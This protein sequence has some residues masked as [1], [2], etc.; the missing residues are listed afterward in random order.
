MQL[1]TLALNNNNCIYYL[2]RSN[3]NNHSSSKKLRL[4]TKFIYF[5]ISSFFLL[6]FSSCRASYRCTGHADL[7]SFRFESNRLECVILA[8]IT[9]TKNRLIFSTHVY[10]CE[11]MMCCV[12]FV[13]GFGYSTWSSS[14]W[15]LRAALERIHTYIHT[16]RHVRERR[17][18]RRLDPS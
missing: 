12:L 5:S 2:T 13:G 18:Q 6:L 1:Y 7:D 8:Q 4:S 9:N 15:S 14:S 17:Q 3:N 11:S 16:K 10:E